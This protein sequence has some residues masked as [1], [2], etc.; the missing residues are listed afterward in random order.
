MTD[1]ELS[2]IETIEAQLLELRLVVDKLDRLV[3]KLFERLKAQ[4]V[5]LDA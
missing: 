3:F 5:G 4:Q 1:Q 2:K